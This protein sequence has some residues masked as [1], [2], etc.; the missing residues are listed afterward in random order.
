[1]T[2]ASRAPSTTPLTGITVLE[3]SSS[4]AGAYTGRLLRDVGARVVR[5]TPGTLGKSPELDTY[6][7]VG[8]E[9]SNGATA[10]L[11]ALAASLRADIVVL[12]LPDAPADDLVHR[13][14]A[15]VVVV[16]TPWGL[17]GP[18]A[19]VGRP[20]TEFTLQVEAGSGSMRGLMTSCPVVTGS[21]ESLWTA[22]A[23]AAGAAV[24]ALQGGSDGRILDISLLE[25]T[26]YATNLFQDVAAAVVRTPKDEPRHRI[27]L[28]PSVEPASDG[29]VGFNLA[30][31]QNHQ[32][33]LVLIERP[34]WLT[35]AQMNNFMGR[36]ARYEEW[37]SAVRDW[38]RQHT[39]AEIVERAAKLRI[40]CS[41][42]HNGQ[43]VLEDAQV[44]D[45][46]LYS[47]LPGV[48]P[49]AP[50]PPLLIG[51]VRP[52]RGVEALPA[53]TG[54]TPL[55]SSGGAPFAGLKVVDLGTWWVGA[56]VGSTLGAFGADVL[57][58]ESTRRID[59]SR[60][61][62]GVPQTADH[63]WECGN[64]YLGANFNK[65]NVTLDFSQ[66]EGREALV[67][68]IE[69]ADIL[70][71]NFAPRVLESV[72]LDWDAVHAINPRLVMLRMPAFGLSGPRRSMVGYAQTVEQYSGLC[73]RTG[74]EGG[75]PT[76]PSG[77]ADPM[78]G[79]NSFF[80][81]AAA[82]LRARSSGA[83]VLVEAP[84][85]EGAL[86]MSA[87]QVLR[88][89]SRGELLERRGNRSED[90]DF[91]GLFPAAGTQRW[92]GVSVADE[93]QWAAL[94]RITGSSHW[95]E[96]PRLEDRAGRQAQA[97]LL[98]RAVGA[99]IGMLSAE[100]AVDQLLAGGV[101]A[102]V[103]GDARFMHEHP[104][105]AGRGAYELTDLPHVGEIALPTLPFRRLDQPR[106]LTRRPPLLGEHNEEVLRGEL[107]LDDDAM[108][109]LA[110]KHIIGTAP[111]GA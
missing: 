19:G 90:V 58:V 81:L 101:P 59:G 10:D 28:S 17:D 26:T 86:V 83:G 11:P 5:A 107:G 21:S 65:R 34:E 76:N 41:P 24:A 30:S 72:G 77:P 49:Q 8:K 39:V 93:A 88:W 45:R 33:F 111:V 96:D 85:A 105:L 32:D 64:F 92:V 55:P 61:L 68:L 56:Y 53:G 50:N 18:W 2:G 37:T 48:E 95:L 60:T 43:T 47:P 1:V 40:P 71:E 91:Q 102:A 108:R 94:A 12:E 80:A 6:L 66:P 74:Y 25:V 73:W 70:I 79:A 78:G 38:T 103:L 31:P 27:R 9:Q 20:W 36:Y 57:K 97:D 62:G 4:I 82:L 16:V 29:W 84:L 109:M 110:E 99:W 87:E 104:H 75:D 67:R 14:G 54:P 89:T 44:V 106:W 69:R 98:D 13:F 35:D 51:G 46:D 3:W 22:G 52:T 42:V 23:M 100:D 63:W 15:A 7:G